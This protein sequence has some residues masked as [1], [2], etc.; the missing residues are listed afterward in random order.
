MC[1]APTH[2]TLRDDERG[3][4]HEA[5]VTTSGGFAPRRFGIFVAMLMLAAGCAGSSSSTANSVSSS[6]A[7]ESP[8]EAVDTSEA[9]AT[10][11]SGSSEAPAPDHAATAAALLWGPTDFP[12][13]WTSASHQRSADYQGGGDRLAACAGGVNVQAPVDVD[14]LDFTDGTMRAE[15]NAA[16]HADSA[17]VDA[18]FAAID[19]PQFVDCLRDELIRALGANAQRPGV[20]VE[21][22]RNPPPT[23]TPT[24]TVAFRATV[25]QDG[26]ALVVSDLVLMGSGRTE[27]SLEFTGKRTAFPEQLKADLV[28]NTAARLAANPS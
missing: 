12:S 23:G 18:D 6:S 2:E 8:L 19:G 1:G 15:M 22:T 16:I 28:A 13:D 25:S 4:P 10:E 7:A 3:T 5:I 14:A 9:A 21:V 20:A 27:L 17:T 24:A 26:V 11:E